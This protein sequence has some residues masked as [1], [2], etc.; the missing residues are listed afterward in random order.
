MQQAFQAQPNGADWEE[1]IEVL[2]DDTGTAF[3]LSQASIEVEIAD[4]YNRRRLIGTLADGH[5]DLIDDGFSFAFTAAEMRNLAAGSY[6]VNIRITDNATGFV[7]E[8]VIAMLPILE[9]GFR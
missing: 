2:D 9:G 3:D 7:M 8:P 5:V 4:T 6:T 1:Y